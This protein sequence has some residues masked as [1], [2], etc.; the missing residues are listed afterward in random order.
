MQV[1]VFGLWHLGC[2]TAA[3]LAE[4]GH[5]VVGLDRDCRVIEGLRRG[6]PPLFEPGLTELIQQ[7][8]AAGRLRFTDDP[9]DALAGSELVWVTFDTPVN[10]RDEAD[11]AFVRRELEAVAGLLSPE[12]LLL[13]SSQVPVG[14]SR[15]LERDWAGRG[16]RV[17]VSPENLRLGKALE[18]F[19]N[20]ERM[21]VGVRSEADRRFL[22]PLLSPIC[23]RIEWMSV[24][25]AEMTKHA[26]NAF[27]A[28]SVTFINE[29]ARLCEAVGADAKEVERGLKSEARIGPQ[30]Y[31]APGGAIAGGT[32]KRD[33]QFLARRGRDCEVATPLVSGVLASNAA[34]ED[35]LRRHLERLLAGID[36]PVVTLLGL[37]YKPGT[38]TLRRSSS[39]E[40]G[41]WLATRG[42]RVKACDPAVRRLPPELS[43]L[44]ELQATAEEALAGADA[45]VVATEWPVFRE[46]NPQTLAAQMRRPCLIDPNHFLSAPMAQDPRLRYIATGRAA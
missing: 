28:T 11:V 16:V 27:L 8:S 25:S 18:A 31:L 39:I 7:Q 34:H 5:Q 13:L 9:R 41:R 44:I 26:L 23:R 46:L 14:F 33:L 45:A 32:L 19:R 3:C 6:E 30:A 22:E 15:D 37:T 43:P 1:T 24:E 2:V 12:Q 29:I 40:L 38:D 35:W 42:V 4:A 36:Q 10:E 17:A 20:S 21:V